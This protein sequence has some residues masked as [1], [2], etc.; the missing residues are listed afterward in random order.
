MMTAIAARVTE[1]AQPPTTGALAGEDVALIKLA[2]TLG[3][4]LGE[5]RPAIY[6]ADTAASALLGWGALA[7]LILVPGLG[8]AATAALAIVAV[9][10]LYR[11]GS[12][13]HEISHMK[14]DSVPGYRLGWN[15]V[16]GIPLMIPSFMYEGVHNLHHARNRYGTVRDPEYMALA[17]KPKLSVPLFVAVAALGPIGLLIRW[18]IMAPL[19]LLKPVRDQV[20]ARFSALSINPDFRRDPPAGPAAARWTL[21]EVATSAFVI[22]VLTGVATGVIP[23]RAFAIWL[24]VLSTTM[25]LNQVRTLAAHLWENDGKVMS[26]TAQFLD[27]VN[28]PPPALLPELWAPVGLRY[29]A[30][31]HLL[32]SVPYHALPAAH[33]RLLAELPADNAYH[34]GNHPSLTGVIARLWA[35]AGTARA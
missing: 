17:L 13:I 35:S 19:S 24:A 4:E 22:A 30:L 10:A 32:P 31:H 27:S 33:R 11:L 6:W 29:H 23:L 14:D 34:G 2:A 5:Y 1:S 15:L 25:V 3:R 16:A 20:R 18:G 9:L 21:M 28:V 12:F 7:A 26:I 8:G